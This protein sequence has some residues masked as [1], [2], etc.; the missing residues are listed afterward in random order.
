MEEE[1]KGYSLEFP[2]K[3]S[4]QFCCR[5]GF[6]IWQASWDARLEEPVC[7]S[8]TGGHLPRPSIT[9][10][11]PMLAPGLLLLYPSGSYQSAVPH[12]LAA[13]RGMCAVVV[14]VQPAGNSRTECQ[15]TPRSVGQCV[16][17]P[18]KK[19]WEDYSNCQSSRGSSLGFFLPRLN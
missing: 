3:H 19:T 7:R 10:A 16:N 1:G 12:E 14:G 11:S 13:G 17:E 6:S 5:E 9:T 2:E 8:C 15:G 18:T 4:L